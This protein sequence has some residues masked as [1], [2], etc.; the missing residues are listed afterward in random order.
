MQSAIR[1]CREIVPNMA[2]ST[3]ATSRPMLQGSMGSYILPQLHT[4]LAASYRSSLTCHW[5]GQ[6]PRQRQN[7]GATETRVRGEEANSASPGSQAAPK[8]LS[9]HCLLRLEWWFTHHKRKFVQTRKHQ[10]SSFWV[11]KCGC[12]NNKVVGVEFPTWRRKCE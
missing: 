2:P 10:Q 7:G 12:G 1:S 11:P 9:G 3:L 8:Y 6:A 5:D 4:V